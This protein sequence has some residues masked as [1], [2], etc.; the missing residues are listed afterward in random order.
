MDSL[1]P[2]MQKVINYLEQEYS[3]L[4]VWRANSSMVDWINVYIPSWGMEQKVNQIA[5]STIIDS[6]TIKIQPWDKSTLSSIEKAIY[7]S[8]LW[9]TPINQWD[10]ILI[11]IPPLTT[12]RRKDL[13]KVVSKMW[14]E[15]KISLRNIRHEFMKDIKTKFE[16]DEI[17]E[18][19][20]KLQEKQVEDTMKDYTKRIEDHVKHKS[21]EIMK[22]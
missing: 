4:Q 2:Q 6:Q 5:N 21:E 16:N 11:N 14:E 18:D 3:Q 7:D 1:K 9:L 15:A 19:E 10:H 22:I 12:E 8:G 17:S 13:T 20:K